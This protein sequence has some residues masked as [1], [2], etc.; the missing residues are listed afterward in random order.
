MKETEETLKK[1]NPKVQYLSVPTD[2]SNE[3]SVAALFEKVKSTFGTVDV[4]VNNAGV[5]GG[6]PNKLQDHDPKEWWSTFVSPS[7][8]NLVAAIYLKLDNN[9]PTLSF[10]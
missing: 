4:I 7:R 5:N 8:L 2:I 6:E 3:E 1:V 10:H 9:C